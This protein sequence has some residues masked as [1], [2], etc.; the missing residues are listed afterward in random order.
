M[1]TTAPQTCKALVIRA[2]DG[3]EAFTL[4]QEQIPVPKPLP[5]QAL[6]KVAVAAQNP[7]DV[8][9][10]DGG[11]FGDGSVLGCDFVGTVVA[12]GAEV[13]LVQA[14]DKIAG[15][16]WGGEIKG[17]G[18]YSQYTIA[19][20]KI[21]FK[22]PDRLSLEEAATV[23]LTATTAWLALFRSA[24]LAI[25]RNKGSAINLLVWAGST[26]CG[27]YAIQIAALFGFNIG[28]VCSPSQASRLCSLGAN[29]IFDYKD[30]DV[31]SKIKQAMP[32][33]DYIFDTIGTESSSTLASQAMNPAGGTLCT[34]RPFR[35]HT[36]DVTSQTKVTSVLV[37]TSFFKN[38]TMGSNLLPA[39]EE[40][41]RL[42]SEFYEKIPQLLRQGKIKPNSPQL[43]QGGLD[44]IQEGFQMYRDGK[45]RRN[46]VVYRLE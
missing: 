17:Q 4:V 38:H 43:I 29:H 37:F 5:H 7:T 9:C 23:P 13:T 8:L 15:L 22:I 32:S 14:G 12:V 6:V 40:D 41:H 35:E 3:K 21:C 26:S 30:P 34:V 18:A 25:D 19:D 44:G 39:S 16:I 46:K 28:T 1:T 10:Y 31:I 45:I 27:L 2:K 33:V 11:V 20:E 36:E 24:S 42:A